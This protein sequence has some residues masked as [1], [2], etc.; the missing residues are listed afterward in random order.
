MSDSVAEPFCLFSSNFF[1]PLLSL[2]SNE[3]FLL[4]FLFKPHI[5]T[6]PRP[7]RLAII[8]KGERLWP[9]FANDGF[10]GNLFPKQRAMWC[11]SARTAQTLIPITSRG[12][13][14]LESSQNS[15]TGRAS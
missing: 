7:R 9:L 3:I 13:R 15:L 12:N 14:L 1:L 2:K 10:G 4:V 8:R 11:M 6:E 5:I